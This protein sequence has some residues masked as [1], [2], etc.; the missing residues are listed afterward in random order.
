MLCWPKSIFPWV[1]KPK[2]S[3]MKTYT[4]IIGSTCRRGKPFDFGRENQCLL[5]ENDENVIVCQS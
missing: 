3:A 2:G 1:A 5:R 4:A